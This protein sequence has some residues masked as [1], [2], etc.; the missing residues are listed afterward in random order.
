MNNANNSGIQE[1]KRQLSLMSESDIRDLMV[2]V[3]AAKAKD[4]G[5]PIEL[6]SG[7]E[8]DVAD[9]PEDGAVLTVVWAIEDRSYQDWYGTTEEA[10]SALSALAV[11]H[12]RVVSGQSVDLTMP[13][14][15]ESYAHV[16]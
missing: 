8:G 1:I 11:K 12:R 10:M 2:E 13:G 16:K 15:V 14:C 4:S 5:S 3:L 9:R 6:W 7:R